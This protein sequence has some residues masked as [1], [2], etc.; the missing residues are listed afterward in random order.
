MK[1]LFSIRGKLLLVSLALLAIPVVGYRFVTHMEAFLRES[2]EEALVGTTRAIAASL[3]ER[4]GLF[5]RRDTTP[6]DAAEL[7]RRQIVALFGGSDP[8]AVA[9]LGGA[10][11]P[12]PDIERTLE[13]LGRSAA[14][15]WV[16]D[17]ASRVRGL[18][19]SLKPKR[20]EAASEAADAYRPL[21]RALVRLLRL[22]TGD[23]KDDPELGQRAVMA[24]VD[25][26]LIG[27][28]SAV[29]RYTRD[30]QGVV[31]SAAQP[32]WAGDDIVGAVVVEETTG[33]IQLLKLEAL[34]N[35]LTITL[36]VFIAGFVTLI[37]FAWRLAA[38]VRTL[39]RA[40]D[41]AI[42][43]QGRIRGDLAPSD[44][45]DE[46]GELSRNLAATVRRLKDYNQHLESLAARLSHELR[47]P[48]AVV[49]SSLDNLKL[50]SV[51]PEATVYIERADIGVQRLSTLIGRLSEATQLERFLQGT[52]RETF[53][54]GEVIAG[55]IEGYRATFPSRIF[56]FTNEVAG[57]TLVGVPDAIAQLLDKLVAN[58]IDFH[59]AG[60]PIDIRLARAGRHLVLTVSNEGPLLPAGSSATLFSSM[61]SHRA[62]A[63]EEGGHLGMG[64]YIVRLIAE[65]HGGFPEAANR[66][67]G[68]GVEIRVWLSPGSGAA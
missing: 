15:I 37:L 23:A 17:S 47:T 14:R 59:V 6:E 57:P 27:A 56:A 29:W 32:V 39:G 60:T 35:L 4:P 28:P 58:A 48:V 43:A 40:A 31:L 54:P 2:Q 20:A 12:S 66:A 61:V 19:G 25:R 62:G 53:D 13:L 46:L 5:T 67:D 45:S 18:S 42:D 51:S 50:Q 49:R 55:C 68:R 34:E 11:Q 44:A 22:P 16:V 41:A 21:S 9:T 30:R 38:R 63:S 1:F 64:L 7:E 8:E 10:Y 65:Y 33:A 52:E 36:I 26:A 24:Q 3:S